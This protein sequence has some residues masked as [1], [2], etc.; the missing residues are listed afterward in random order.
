MWHR[1]EL[2]DSGGTALMVGN[3][4]FPDSQDIEKHTK[5]NEEV[6]TR[7]LLYSREG[8]HIVLLYRRE[9]HHIVLGG[10]F[11]AHIDNDNLDTAGRLLLDT[12]DKAGLLLVNNMVGI[13]SGGPT[14][15]Q[16]RKDGVQSSTI[17]FVCVSPSLA[18]NLVSL[19]ISVDQLGSDHRPLI[20][21]L[22]NMRTI[23]PPKPGPREVWKV[24]SI[25]SPLPGIG[26]TGDWTGVDACQ[27]Q[28]RA[29]IA[30]AIGRTQALEAVG[31]DSDCV[32][33]IMEWSFQR[34][35][36]EV[37]GSMLGTKFVGP[38]GTPTVDRALD[39]LVSQKKVANSIM[40]LV[41]EDSTASDEDKTMAR[42]QFLRLSR[43]VTAYSARKKELAE[44]KLFRDVEANQS[45]SKLFW[46]KFKSLRGSTKAGKAPPPVVH[47]EEGQTVTDPNE[48]LRVW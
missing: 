24:P 29:W 40:K 28:F 35:L 41:C 36:D 37:A 4:Y 42:K 26:R 38:P 32:A 18:S 30:N 22:N 1:V 27:T 6:L 31:T 39:L 7:L 34:A 9:G 8:H 14:R 2:K 20:L 48:V 16:V 25:P 43:S 11:N 44:L 10:D 13:C 47:D 5:A 21:R 15:V 17:D 23:P 3:C 19:T 12:I 33:D 46:G 45:D